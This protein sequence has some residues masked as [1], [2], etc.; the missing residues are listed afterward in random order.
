MRDF[1]MSKINS[2][3]TGLT[4]NLVKFLPVAYLAQ[5]VGLKYFTVSII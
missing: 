1:E 3:V 2:K 5:I 4:L